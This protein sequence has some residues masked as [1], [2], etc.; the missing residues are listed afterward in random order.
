MP[1]KRY[2]DPVPFVRDQDRDYR[3]RLTTKPNFR[4]QTSGL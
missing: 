1:L 2:P 3:D 4:L